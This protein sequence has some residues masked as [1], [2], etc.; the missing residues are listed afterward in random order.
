MKILNRR[1][2]MD[3][4]SFLTRW[5]ATLIQIV[6]DIEPFSSGSQVWRSKPARLRLHVHKVCIHSML[7]IVLTLTFSG[8]ELNV[9][10]VLNCYLT[11]WIKQ[12]SAAYAM[13]WFN[14][15]VIIIVTGAKLWTVDYNIIILLLTSWMCIIWNKCSFYDIDFCVPA[16]FSNVYKGRPLRD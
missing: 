10:L 15:L 14:K 1:T 7:R 6:F 12:T 2:I 8:S 13:H 5:A 9:A 4:D 11:W 16:W 3:F